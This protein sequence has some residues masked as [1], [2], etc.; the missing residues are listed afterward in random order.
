[1]ILNFLRIKFIHKKMARH[2]HDYARHGMK[3]Y[4]H[5]NKWAGLAWPGLFDTSTRYQF[6]AMRFIFLLIRSFQT[7]PSVGT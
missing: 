6:M 1:M 2:E 5:G 4:E 3:H 7:E